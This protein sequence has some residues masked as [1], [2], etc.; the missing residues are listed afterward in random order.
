MC[1]SVPEQA[2]VHAENWGIRYTS[3]LVLYFT[4]QANRKGGSYTMDCSHVL[5]LGVIMHLILMLSGS[6][7]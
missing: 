3:D 6:H 1:V 5:S 2:C 4:L 7:R